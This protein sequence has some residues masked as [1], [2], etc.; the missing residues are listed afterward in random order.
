VYR[1]TDSIK[2]NIG[3]MSQSFSLYDDLTPRENIRFFGGIYG[4]D[5]SEI[6]EKGEH[7]LDSLDLQEAPNTRLFGSATTRVEADLSP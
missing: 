4:L 3:Y 5:K 2:R 1:Q 7:L 6:R